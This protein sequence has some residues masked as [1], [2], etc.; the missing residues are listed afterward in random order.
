[1]DCKNWAH[2]SRSG[3]LY[4]LFVLGDGHQLLMAVRVEPPRRSPV[5]GVWPAALSPQ[6]EAIEGMPRVPAAGFTQLKGRQGVWGLVIGQ[7]LGPSGRAAL[8][9]SME[10]MASGF[11]W[12]SR[13]C[14]VI[15]TW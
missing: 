7:G 4:R 1:M 13:G 9:G 2:V 11:Q 5:P 15:R 6:P 12:H 10:W 8:A 3:G 14:G